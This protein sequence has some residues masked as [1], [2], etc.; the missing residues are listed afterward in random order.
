VKNFDAIIIGAGQ[1]G[2]SLAG[3]LTGAGLTVASVERK[4]FGGTCANTGCMPTKTLVASAYA[5]HLARRAADYGIV[6][7]GAI[8]VDMKKVKARA[9][10]VSTNA[11]TGVENYLR[12]MEGCTVIEEHACF[13]GPDRVRVGEELL[14][15]PRIF[16]NVGGRAIV[17]DMPGVSK[18]PYLTNTS[19]LALD[20]LT[21][22]LVVI[23]GSYVGPEFAQVYRRFGA[24]VTVIEK[25]PRLVA[26]ED[27]GI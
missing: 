10:A 2:P 3:R 12:G 7:D 18:V 22:H 4:L 16:I 15:A 21:D 19:M 5:A 11:H 1:A 17:P 26:R 23:G 9:D 24:P 14:T 13:E 27:E 8:R 20:H 6:L 25:G